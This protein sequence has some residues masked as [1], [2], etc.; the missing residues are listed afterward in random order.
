MLKHAALPMC[1]IRAERVGG[2]ISIERRPLE[3]MCVISSF[4]EVFPD[5]LLYNKSLNCLN[6]SIIA[7]GLVVNFKKASVAAECDLREDQHDFL[8]W[9]RKLDTVSQPWKTSV[10]LPCSSGSNSVEGSFLQYTPT[11]K[12]THSSSNPSMLKFAKLQEQPRHYLRS[13][14]VWLPSE[15][16]VLRSVPHGVCFFVWAWL[17]VL[18]TSH[19]A[20]LWRQNTPILSSVLDLPCAQWSWTQSTKDF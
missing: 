12:L 16:L 10:P 4:T 19:S 3:N 15:I 20:T 6:G 1:W 7:S 2:T 8:P 14:S 17:N 9:P 11:P 5:F 18:K 13:L